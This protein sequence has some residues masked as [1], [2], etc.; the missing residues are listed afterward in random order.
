MCY[1]SSEFLTGR[2]LGLYLM[3]M[4]LYEAAEAVATERGFELGQILE[5]EGD[6]GLGNGGLGR[7]AACFM[8]SLATLELPAFG[9]GIRYDFGM[10]EQKI[11]GGR[12]LEQ[13]DN[14]LQ[15]GNAWELP[16]HEDA[17]TVRFGGRVEFHRDM[18]GTLRASWVD[19]RA[20]IGLPY[21]S[22]IVGHRTDTVNTLRLW[23]A[24]AT[25]DFDLQFFNDG[26]FRRAVEEKIDT[27]NISKVL[28]PNDSSEEGKMLRLKQQ[29]FFVACSIADIVKRYKG[30]HE[31]FDAFP[32]KV[33][34]QLN[35]THPSI[36]VA[37]LMRVL[38]DE[39]RLDWDKAWSITH[40]TLG[41]HEPHAA[42]RGARDVAGGAV[43]EA[44]A[45]PHLQIIFEI[46][47][48]FPC[49]TCSCAGRVISIA[50]A[51]CR[52]STR[53]AGGTSAWPTWPRSALTAST[54]S[55][56]CTPTSSRNSSFTFYELWPERF[57]NKTNGVT[58]REWILHANPRLTQLVTRAA[59]GPRGSTSP[60]SRACTSSRQYADDDKFLDALWRVKQQNKADVVS[61]V[62]ARTGVTLPSEA[63][64]VVQVKR[65]HEYKRQLLACLQIISHY[66]AIR[67]D[68]ERCRRRA[69]TSSGQGRPRL[70]HGQAAHPPAQRR[71]GGHQRR[72]R[73]ARAA[74]HGLR[75]ELR[76]HA[77]PEPSSPRPTSRLQ[78]STAGKEGPRG[79]RTT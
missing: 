44:A 66:L 15:L 63:M 11:D 29:Y 57:N 36:A 65:I 34:I 75:A 50:C 35:D 22:F 58:P 56:R 42:A 10:F 68:P 74:L 32:D 3:N 54:A 61:L 79:T 4:G 1:L 20:V 9:Y 47:Q 67:R 27:E 71:R 8:D 41:L 49:T 77:R 78:I 26:D 33:A 40:R 21:D 23:A 52:S 45:A 43:R 25:R 2:S 5:Q 60:I 31:T 37:E 46:N 6:P 59:S 69:P 13:H 62:E 73:R 24:R 17:Q 53:A 72:P 16:R 39:E 48:R 18:N 55:R 30:K 19:A 51:T 38:I 14:W 12:Q 76:R 7:L 70:H 64:F 28:Y